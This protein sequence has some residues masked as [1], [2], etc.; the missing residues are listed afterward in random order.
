MTREEGPHLGFE[1][2]IV[3]GKA[4][5]E[6]R[7]MEYEDVN[8]EP[9][10]VLAMAVIEDLGDL[11]DERLLQEIDGIDEDR[12]LLIRDILTEFRSVSSATDWSRDQLA[13]ML[14]CA[15]PDPRMW[16]RVEIGRLQRSLDVL[17]VISGF[18]IKVADADPLFLLDGQ[19]HEDR[20]RSASREALG[21]SVEAIARLRGAAGVAK[22]VLCETDAHRHIQEDML[23]IARQETLRLVAAE[24]ERL[25]ALG[26]VVAQMP[27]VDP[28]P[29]D[30]VSTFDEAKSRFLT[31]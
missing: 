6:A 13:P 22:H 19:S 7:L 16:A 10:L 21:L 26:E 3:S 30:S 1:R 17:R 27:L 5:P 24:R 23:G 11:E 15:D 18:V 25:R 28:A 9:S 12:S 14:G 31:S 20:R 29:Y 8:D 4:T 2:D